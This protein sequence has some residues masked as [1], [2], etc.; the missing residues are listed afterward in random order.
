[1][2]HGMALGRDDLCLGLYLILFYF[3]GRFFSRQFV[4]VVLWLLVADKRSLLCP[5]KSFCLL[6]VS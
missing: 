2:Y 5:S 1:M 4:V 6:Y 3:S